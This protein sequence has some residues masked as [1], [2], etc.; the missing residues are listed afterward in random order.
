MGTLHPDHA[1]AFDDD[2]AD[3]DQ[4]EFGKFSVHLSCEQRA[5]IPE[6]ARS[7][8]LVACY[9]F[10]DSKNLA[11]TGDTEGHREET[12]LLMAL[13]EYK[14]KRRFEDTPEP[15]PEVAKDKGNRL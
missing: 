6:F 10:A 9:N 4:R 14:R 2:G 15:P 1:I 11:T 3:A 5:S 7:L 13:E 8:G 12:G